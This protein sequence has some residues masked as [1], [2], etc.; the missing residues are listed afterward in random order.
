[1]HA[2]AEYPQ[3]P[4]DLGPQ[5]PRK[6]APASVN[7]DSTTPAFMPCSVA[8][9]QRPVE[10]SDKLG[11]NGTQT[12]VCHSPELRN[13]PRMSER[14]RSLPE[15]SLRLDQ[16][17]DRAESACRE[18]DREPNDGTYLELELGA[19]DP[20][21]DW[22]DWIVLDRGSATQQADDL[23]TS[24]EADHHHVASDSNGKGSTMA[25]EVITVSLPGQTKSEPGLWTLQDAFFALSG[26]FAVDST[27]FWPC[28]RL[29]FTYA[30]I[31]KLAEL[32]LLPEI[33]SAAIS[34]KSKADIIAKVIVCLQASWFL[35]QSI[36]RL[37]QGLPIT[38]LEIHV[39]TH[40]ACAFGM[41]IL[42][43]DKPYSVEYPIMLSDEA[44]VDMAALFALAT[45]PV[46]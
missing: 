45:H 18:D 35:I 37:C 25:A 40:V 6:S 39:L 5:P 9:E 22:D 21:L 4:Q 38:L 26:G 15:G 3:Q 8:G 46:S 23:R 2:H 34:D 14:R 7:D 43:L 17:C 20:A 30:G 12:G 16:D 1:M 42:W 27:S 33:S 13:E 36:A 24:A 41:Y 44:T 31:I 19:P 10:C 29:T 28:S 32:E 11:G